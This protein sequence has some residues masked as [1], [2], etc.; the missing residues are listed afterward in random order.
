MNSLYSFRRSTCIGAWRLCDLQVRT[1]AETAGRVIL[2][3]SSDAPL[4]TL[5]RSAQLSSGSKSG[6]LAFEFGVSLSLCHGLGRRPR[7]QGSSATRCSIHLRA[8]LFAGFRGLGA[9]HDGPY[10]VLPFEWLS[11]LEFSRNSISTS[12]QRPMNHRPRTHATKPGQP[13]LTSLTHRYTCKPKVEP[14][15]A[16]LIGSRTTSSTNKFGPKGF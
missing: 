13:Y 4:L 1:E 11:Y 12:Q 6:F 2:A 7:V 3:T 8:V 10:L 15:I 5:G 16:H 9:E 14:L